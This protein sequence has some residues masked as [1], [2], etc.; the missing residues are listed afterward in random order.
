MNPLAI[1]ESFPSRIERT[2]AL[3]AGVVVV[4]VLLVGGT[5]LALAVRIYLNNDA[6]AQEYDHIL[7]LGQAHSLFD[8][9]FFE[10]HQMDST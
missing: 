10:L 4:A 9:M 3:A 2:L 6:V 7:R 5:S 8:D 1:E